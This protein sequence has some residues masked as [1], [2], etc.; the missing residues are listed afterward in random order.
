MSRVI[1]PKTGQGEAKSRPFLVSTPPRTNRVSYFVQEERGN[2]AMS[3]GLM[4][5]VMCMV[6]GAAV[7]IG[8]WMDARTQTETAL[9]AAV[10]A[11]L[12]KYQNTGDSTAALNTAMLNYKYAVCANATDVAVGVTGCPNGDV[13]SLQITTDTIAFKLQANNTQMTAT[14]DVSIATPFLSLARVPALPLLK[15]D[16]TELP[17]SKAMAATPSKTG[18]CLEVSMMIDISKTMDDDDGLGNK[19]LDDV[20]KAAGDFVESVVES[21]S[22]GC[23]AKVAIIPF[24]NTVCMSD[25]AGTDKMCG[26]RKSGYAATPGYQTLLVS[27]SSSSNS[28]GD[29]NGGDDNHSG[30]GNGYGNSNGN[31]H[32]AI[33]NY[34]TAS[35]VDGSVNRCGG[36]GN[37]GGDRGRGSDGN[38]D[39]NSNKGGDGNNYTLSNYTQY[40]SNSQCV[41]ERTDSHAYTDDD[42]ASYKLA[43]HYSSD[44]TSPTSSTVVHLTDDKTKLHTCING[45]TASGTKAGHLGTAHAWYALSPSFN[46]A[47]DSNSQARPY[48]DLTAKNLNGGPALKKVAVLMTDGDYD[49][50]YCD[51]GTDDHDSNAK[52]TSPNGKSAAQAA[53]VCTNMKAKGIEVYTI[54][55]KVSAT[56]KAVLQ[57][58]ATDANHYLDAT[59]GNKLKAAYDTIAQKL[60]PLY[61]SH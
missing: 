47:R 31:N 6:T 2:V 45:L 14:G 8:R 16:G 48:S 35:S 52:C 41:T 25:S 7:D 24:S 3:F 18:T 9:D 59:D 61:L 40:K 39:N 60:V 29:N 12:K 33:A 55:A 42:P 23:G 38:D 19:K 49:T 51:K 46:S 53:T 20:K 15:S 11:G 57:A 1:H 54:G 30:D 44:G 27:K 5:T 10:L 28:G 22:S 36:G 4:L 50:E 21:A 56:A 17:V 32:D 43:R 26:A 37:D 13:R 34:S 58:C